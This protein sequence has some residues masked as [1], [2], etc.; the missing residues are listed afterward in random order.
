MYQIYRTKADKKDY[1]ANKI[2]FQ[3]KKGIWMKKKII[4]KIPV[5]CWDRIAMYHHVL[6]RFHVLND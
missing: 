1:R 2:I 5:G 6:K 4:I 3:C